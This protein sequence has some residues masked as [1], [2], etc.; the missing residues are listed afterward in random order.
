[1]IKKI[2]V[3]VDFSDHSRNTVKYATE[4]AKKLNADVTLIHAYTLPLVNF[5]A[6]YIPP[7]ED[8]QKEAETEMNLL[9][10][11]LGGYSYN[12]IIKMG[13]ASEVILDTAVEEGFDLIVVSIAGHGFIKEKVIGSTAYSL[14]KESKIPVLIVPVNTE[15]KEIKKVVFACDFHHDLSKTDL[16]IKVENIVNYLGCEL[17]IISVINNEKDV[18]VKF[19]ENYFYFEKKL[20]NIPHQHFFVTHNRA[21]EGILEYIKVRKSDWIIISPLKHTLFEKLFKESVTKEI[22]FHS[23]IP[24]LTLHE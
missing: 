21:A 16:Y 15:Y 2:L 13:F 24:V 5:E 19:A 23:S 11:Q 4:L 9:L 7:I 20:E 6:G 10:N 17:E 22:V 18:N 8:V 3:G 12:T 14:S 1:M